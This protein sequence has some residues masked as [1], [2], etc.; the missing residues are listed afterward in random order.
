MPTDVLRSLKNDLRFT[1]DTLQKVKT[2]SSYLL[3]EEDLVSDM[4]NAGQALL[5]AQQKLRDTNSIVNLTSFIIAAKQIR[6]MAS[7]LL[8]ACKN[9]IKGAA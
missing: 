5:Q 1:K 6:I 7:D 3:L 8:L 9:K 2:L 4:E